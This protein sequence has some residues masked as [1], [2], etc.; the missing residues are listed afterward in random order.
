MRYPNVWW[1]GLLLC[2]LSLGAVASASAA[3]VFKI[4]TL[5]PEGSFWMEKM[6]EGGHEVARQTQGR[7]QFKYY[8]GGVM[9]DD[10][11]VI[12]KMRIGQLQG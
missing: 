10:K 4:A 12:R 5:S 3:T 1:A 8:P 6:R 11:A 7:V 2:A 9:G